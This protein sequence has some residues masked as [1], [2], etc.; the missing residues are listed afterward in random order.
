MV[1][2]D[3][4]RNSV[5]GVSFYLRVV[6]VRLDLIIDAR[7]GT[8]ESPR[9]LCER[10]SS[11]RPVNEAERERG[12]GGVREGDPRKRESVVKKTPPKDSGGAKRLERAREREVISVTE[13][14]TAGVV[15]EKTEQGVC[16]AMASGESSS[17]RKEKTGGQTGS[18]MRREKGVT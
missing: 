12:K 15:V 7:N 13:V 14:N 5:N 8:E 18:H 16:K 9:G 10:S 4:G 1:R 17:K 6:R 3:F 2:G 11:T